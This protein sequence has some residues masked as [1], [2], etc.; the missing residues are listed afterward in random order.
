M[1]FEE[2]LSELPIYNVVAVK[3]DTINH[4]SGSYVAVVNYQLLAASRDKPLCDHIAD[5]LNDEMLDGDRLEGYDNVDVFT[6]EEF[7]EIKQEAA[8]ERKYKY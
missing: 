5:N 2:G 6:N 8:D 7:A 1:A 3:R 4:P